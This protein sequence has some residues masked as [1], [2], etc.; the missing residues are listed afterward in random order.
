[1]EDLLIRAKHLFVA[2]MQMC[3]RAAPWWVSTAGKAG[4]QWHGRA[5][6]RWRAEMRSRCRPRR[7]PGAAAVAACAVPAPPPPGETPAGQENPLGGLPGI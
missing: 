5:I 3:S 7:R 4:R 1:M 2:A 6:R